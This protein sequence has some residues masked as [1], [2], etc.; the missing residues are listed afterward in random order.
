M[1]VAL[2]H[3]IVVD[4]PDDTPEDDVES[5]AAMELEGMDLQELKDRMNYEDYL[6]M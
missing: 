5:V 3:Y 1:E 2:Y 6:V 4:I